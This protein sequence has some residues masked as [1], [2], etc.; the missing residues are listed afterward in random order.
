MA[1]KKKKKTTFQKITLVFVW[2]MLIFTLASV[3][4]GAFSA[5]R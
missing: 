1:K 4:M 3:F 2:I 5:F